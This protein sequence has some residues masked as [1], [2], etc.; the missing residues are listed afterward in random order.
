L[1]ANLLKKTR[2]K[3]LETFW[4]ESKEANDVARMSKFR[5]IKKEMKQ[6]AEKNMS[7]DST[8]PMFFPDPDFVA[9]ST[10][11]TLNMTEEEKIAHEEA[12]LEA[13]AARQAEEDEKDAE[14]LASIEIEKINITMTLSLT[15]M[16]KSYAIYNIS[17]KLSIKA[18]HRKVAKILAND[19]T[20]LAVEF[21]MN[22]NEFGIS[23][24][25]SE[26]NKHVKKCKKQEPDYDPDVEY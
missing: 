9:N 5:A 4:D 19:P 14:L 24:S 13:E 11:S 21:L 20:V 23:A 10:N 6:E 1:S 12:I 22:Q 8:T 2:T 3:I 18:S 16:Y 17:D 26:M 7:T 25:I 15:K